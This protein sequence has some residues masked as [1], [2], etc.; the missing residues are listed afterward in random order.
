M[1]NIQNQKPKTIIIEPE[2]VET[3]PQ[4]QLKLNTRFIDKQAQMPKHIPQQPLPHI[5]MKPQITGQNKSVHRPPY[6]GVSYI[7]NSVPTNV[8]CRGQLH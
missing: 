3:I 8:T 6:E 7:L 1:C 4:P 5:P 2:V